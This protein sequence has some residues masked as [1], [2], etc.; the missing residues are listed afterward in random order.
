MPGVPVTTTAAHENA[1]VVSAN[2]LP[3]AVPVLVAGLKLVKREMLS[4]GRKPAPD[5]ETSVPLAPCVRLARRTGTMFT[6]AVCTRP[7]LWPTAVNVY[8]PGATCG[9]GT[10]TRAAP[11]LVATLFVTNSVPVTLVPR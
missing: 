5:I 6:E 8:R 10:A 3:C 1:P 11:A 9:T 2:V 7:L 4:L